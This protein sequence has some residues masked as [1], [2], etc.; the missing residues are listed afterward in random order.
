MDQTLQNKSDH[1]P[2]TT[3]VALATSTK[4]RKRIMEITHRIYEPDFLTKYEEQSK[5]QHNNLSR[6]GPD[7][8]SRE[9]NELYKA[10]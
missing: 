2:T 3:Y 5:V 8:E 4:I 10:D 7:M 1:W 9:K 6:I